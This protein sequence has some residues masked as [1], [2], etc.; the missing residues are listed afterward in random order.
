MTDSDDSHDHGGDGVSLSDSAHATRGTFEDVPAEARQLLESLQTVDD[1]VYFLA[2]S[3]QA[4][5]FNPASEVVTGFPLSELRNNS[6]LWSERVHV[7]DLWQVRQLLGDRPHSATLDYR[8]RR[9]DGSQRWV[10]S[11]WIGIGDGPGRIL[12]Y[13][14]I[15][16]DVTGRK[17]A[18]EAVKTE[19]DRAQ[20]YLN[21]AGVI[22][23]AINADQKVTMINRKGCESLRCREREVVGGNWFDRFVP[24]RDRE[25]T[26]AVFCQ[27]M[28]GDLEPVEYFENAVV[29][30]DGRECTIAWH[31][32][33]LKNRAGVIIGTL[34][35]GEDITERRQAEQVLRQTEEQFRALFEGTANCILFVEGL[36][37]RFANQA[38]LATFG[39]SR[40]E[41][42][43]RDVSMLHLSQEKYEEAHQ[44]IFQAVRTV[45]FWRGDWP[46][47]KKDGTIVWID[48]YLARLSGGGIVAIL[49]DITER[50][51]AEKALSFRE[52]E[53]SSI[54]R[55][56]PI[57]I[58]VTVE[59]VL[60]QVNQRL[61]EMLGYGSEELVGRSA[62][63]LYPS[64][65]DF[66][67]VGN[68][69]YRQIRESG[70]GTV[71]T[72]WQRKDGRIIDILLS[73]T[74]LDSD[75]LTKGVTFTAL[76]ITER[77][78]DEQALLEKNVAL[79][80]V[81]NQISSGKDALKDQIALNL[82][83]AVMP[84]LQRIKEN[85]GSTQL[86]LLDQLEQ[87]LH[88]VSAPFLETLKDRHPR[89]TP[90]ETE[91]CRLIKNSFT[92]K[93]IAETL[94]ISLAT[95]HKHRELIRRKLGLANVDSNLTS[96]LQSM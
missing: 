63:M 87:E 17:E 46:L 6:S 93:Q 53:L 29:A 79:R 57:G 25:K 39:Y 89:L 15:D 83:E 67:Y 31:N 94:N 50:V 70:S 73:S 27:L 13:V 64:D 48:N 11:H 68:E 2:L 33:L 91:I 62:R 42:I 21:I 35:S 58:G 8:L 85:A 75:D 28:A 84:T 14:C 69:K 55:A 1:M 45:G 22:L 44:L 49:H 72:R 90:R 7:G 19:R 60:T 34:S 59:R 30:S 47:R 77:K 3:G 78:K 40:D 26:R 18:E 41:L 32:T 52:A 43:G 88:N 10:H 80:E 51:E 86:L 54:F 95:V 23:V 71:E 74:A 4:C 81:L 24:E 9:K 76:D 5:C 38:A 36:S 61:C 66:E 20:E 65:K 82:N 56:A 37:I 96:Y 92:S 12:G 16:R